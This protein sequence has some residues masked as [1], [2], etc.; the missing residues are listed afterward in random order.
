LVDN[1]T[2]G[3]ES[4]PWWKRGVIYQIYPRSFQDSNGD[5]TGDLRGII[6]RLEYL[7][8]LEVDAIWLSP[9]YPS[10]MAD[11]GYDVSD[12]CDVDPLFGTLADFDAL[13]EEAHERGIRVIIDFVPNHTSDQH[14]WFLESKSSRDNPKRDWYA[15]R[16]P[17]PDGSPPNNWLAV[18]GGPAW[19]LDETTGQYYHHGFL[20]QQPDLNWRN[21]DVKS[22]MLDALRFW[23]DRGVD[24]FRFDVAHHI[25][26]DPE[27]RDNPPNEGSGNYHKAMGDFDSQIHVNDRMHPDL[28]KMYREIRQLLDSY[29]TEEQPRFMVGETHIYDPVQWASLFGEHLD[30]MHMPGNFGLL[31]SQW[32]A[33]SIR[34]HIDSI[35]A[36][37]PANAW[38]NYVLSNH[39]EPRTA[40]RVGSLQAKVA[41]MLLLTLRG[42]PTLY[43]GEELGMENVEIPEHLQQDPFGLRV[44]GLGLGR[45]PQRTPMQ[46]DP[47]PNAGFCPEGVQP[48][49]PLAPDHQLHNV[50]FERDDPKSILNLAH[51]LLELRK[52]YP[53]LAIG[54]YAAIDGLPAECYVYTRSADDQKLLVALNL[55]NDE[56]QFMLPYTGTG[57]V[58]TSTGKDRTGKISL[59]FM[60]LQPN[61]GILIDITG[62]KL[63]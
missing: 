51:E 15:W 56:H 18:F 16:D 46:W 22:A 11:F 45:D 48:W 38:P 44:P 3:A 41:L 4:F 9:F 5:G 58:V 54:D 37:I 25:M 43:Y 57:Q 60:V 61:E 50:A 62:A 30:E 8:W 40:T 31:R 32:N 27:Y 59:T 33:T 23:L 42:T 52:S 29:D 39:D 35:E 47:S 28:H 20:P 13:V 36:A 53:A 10:P 26:K 49:L 7:A 55:T 2:D 19:T 14:P 34:A 6:D 17:K 24:G 12:Y 63:A 1:S 21:D